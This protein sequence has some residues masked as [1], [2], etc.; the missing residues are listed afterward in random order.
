MRTSLAVTVGQL[1]VSPEPHTACHGPSTPFRAPNPNELPA[2]PPRTV[3]INLPCG[4]VVLAQTSP[5]ERKLAPLA[6]RPKPTSPIVVPRTRCARIS[7]GAGQVQPRHALL[8]GQIEWKSRNELHTG[9]SHADK[10]L[11]R[12]AVTDH[13]PLGHPQDLQRRCRSWEIRSRAGAV[14]PTGGHADNGYA[15]R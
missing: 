4:V 6:I 7:R 11:R 8:A 13:H 15:C 5:N 2:K 9:F 3:S 10:C 1:G 14:L 12:R